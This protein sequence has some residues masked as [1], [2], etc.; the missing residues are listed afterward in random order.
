MATRVPLQQGQAAE[1][2]QGYSRQQQTLCPK[3]M[4]PA[5]AQEE[6]TVPVR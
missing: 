6:A 4:G 2:H 5:A 1:R 3:A